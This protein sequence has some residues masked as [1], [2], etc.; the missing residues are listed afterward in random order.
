MAGAT[1]CDEVDVDDDD[2]GGSGMVDDDDSGGS[3]MVDDDDS[4]GSGMVGTKFQSVRRQTRHDE[5]RGE[6]L[7]RHT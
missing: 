1:R 2:S 3:G 6:W 7:P 5:R 4:G